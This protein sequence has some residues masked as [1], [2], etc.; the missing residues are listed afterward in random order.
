MTKPY[1]NFKWCLNLC[2]SK[3][4]LL[5]YFKFGILFAGIRDNEVESLI[6]RQLFCI[7]SCVFLNT[8]INDQNIRS[9]IKDDTKIEFIMD[10]FFKHTSRFPLAAAMQTH[11]SSHWFQW[12]S[13]LKYVPYH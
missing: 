13:D 6:T 9:F 2:C 5:F 7:S 11:A 10:L 1:K 3:F 8:C 4:I 12:H